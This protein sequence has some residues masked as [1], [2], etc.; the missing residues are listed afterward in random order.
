MEKIIYKGITIELVN[1]YYVFFM[2]G[3]KNTNTTIHMAKRMITKHLNLPKQINMN[4]LKTKQDKLNEQYKAES[5]SGK[6]FWYIMGG[7]LLLT[8]L[9]ENI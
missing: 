4:K 9:I 7:A 5:L 1:G 2:N 8:A 3:T 6:W